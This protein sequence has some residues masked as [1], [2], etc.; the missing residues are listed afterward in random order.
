MHGHH[1]L[2]AADVRAGRVDC[3][4]PLERRQA[5][6]G[7]LIARSVATLCRSLY[8]RMEYSREISRLDASVSM[9]CPC[10]S[11]ASRRCLRKVTGSGYSYVVVWFISMRRMADGR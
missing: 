8:Q 6:A 9:P 11:R 5:G 4:E 7:R 10:L 3:R 1:D 2:L